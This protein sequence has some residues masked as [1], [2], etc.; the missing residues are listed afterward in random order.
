[1]PGDEK[2]DEIS[3]GSKYLKMEPFFFFNK[4]PCAECYA[5][6][7]GHAMKYFKHKLKNMTVFLWIFLINFFQN[8]NKKYVFYYDTAKKCIRYGFPK[9]PLYE[10]L[11][12]F[13]I[14]VN[15]RVDFAVQY[16]IHR[17]DFFSG[18]MVFY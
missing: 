2:A 16:P 18:A 14:R 3:I 8:V 13:Q 17:T 10:L 1:M 6:T 4:T 9:I 7:I 12:V 11:Y 15:E 5:F